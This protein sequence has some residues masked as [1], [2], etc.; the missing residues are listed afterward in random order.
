MVAAGRYALVI[1]VAV[2]LNFALPRMMPGS[3]IALLAGSDVNALT[4]AER[5]A[6]IAAAGLDASLATQYLRYLG[7]LAGGDLGYSYQRHAPVR[8]VVSERLPRSLLLTASSQAVALVLGLSLGVWSAVR[9]RRTKAPILLLSVIAIDALPVYGVGMVLLAVFAS[10]LAWFP[11]FGAVSPWQ[12]PGGWPWVRDVAHHLVLPALALGLASVGGLFLVTRAAVGGA[13]SEPFVRAARARGA[14]PR[15]ILRRHVLASVALPVATVVVLNGALALGSTTLVETVF[16]YPGL[17][18]L[19]YEA[20]LSRD[21]P[22]LQAVFLVFT[23]VVVLANAALDMVAPRLD[24]RVRSSP[25][26]AE[27]IR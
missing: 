18:R 27:G 9:E 6:L 24:P 14:R 5:D 22:V 10:A 25:A 8:Q 26:L 21:Y 23:I 19:T 13:L 4:S 15:G 7:Q 11:T 3:P 2:S 17:G 12:T 20:V 16:A 1:W